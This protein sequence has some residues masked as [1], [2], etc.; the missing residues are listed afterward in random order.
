MIMTFAIVAAALG[1]PALLGLMAL[2]ER[3]STP[4]ERVIGR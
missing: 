2:I 1:M 4:I 3:P